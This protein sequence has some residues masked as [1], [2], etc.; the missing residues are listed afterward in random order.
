MS[1]ALGND[2]KEGTKER[3]GAQGFTVVLR[4]TVPPASVKLSDD[5]LGDPE[6]E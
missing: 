4:E 1:E 2:I 5:S 3:P 6:P